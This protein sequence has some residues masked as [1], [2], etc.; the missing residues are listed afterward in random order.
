MPTSP[1]RSWGAL[2]ESIGYPEPEDLEQTRAVILMFFTASHQNP[3]IATENFFVRIML[4]SHLSAVP[5]RHFGEV[6][7]RLQTVL[8]RQTMAG[9]S[10][11]V[12]QMAI[13]INCLACYSGT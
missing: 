5:V 9:I 6:L 1:I 4:H 2:Y 8:P 10:V 12:L 3:V 13:P 11:E 7:T